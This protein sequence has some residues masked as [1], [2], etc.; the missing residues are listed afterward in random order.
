MWRRLTA[1][2]VTGVYL[3]GE[4]AVGLTQIRCSSQHRQR[5][6]HRHRQLCFHVLDFDGLRS[7][8]SHL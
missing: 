4:G 6:A 7:R 2:F 3:Y 8:Q 1:R 5:G